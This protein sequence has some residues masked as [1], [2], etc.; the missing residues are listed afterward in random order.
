MVWFTTWQEAGTIFHIRSEDAKEIITFSPQKAYSSV[1]LCTPDLKDGS[2]YVVY[3]GGSSTGKA[4]DGLYSG[5]TY[6]PG[7]Q[8]SSFTIS[9]TVI[10]A[11]AASGGSS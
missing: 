7:E 10:Y 4:T 5:G 11:R 9:S 2:N 3:S 6:I 1:A 8:V